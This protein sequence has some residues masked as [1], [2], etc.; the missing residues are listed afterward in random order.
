[1]YWVGQKVRSGFSVTSYGKT[2]TNFLANPIPQCYMIRAGGIHG[3]RTV[4][5]EG[6]L[7]SY[8][9][10]F[11]CPEGSVPLTPAL[12]RGQLYIHSLLP[13]SCPH[14]G[15]HSLQKENSQPGSSSPLPKP[16]SPVPI[17]LPL[18]QAVCWRAEFTD[19]TL[20]RVLVR[21]TTGG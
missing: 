15:T 14:R 8:T 20:Q 16:S 11:H 17:T 4:D 21:S 10:V 1:M 7:Y 19:H 3:C 2:H 6:W 13:P 12:F 9:W 5:T 18:Q